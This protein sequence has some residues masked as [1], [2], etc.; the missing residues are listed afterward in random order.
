MKR[1]KICDV[2]CTWFYNIR[3]RKSGFVRHETDDGEDDESAE[4]TRSTV[5]DWNDNGVATINKHGDGE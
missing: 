2:I 1:E 4:E 3:H 5:D